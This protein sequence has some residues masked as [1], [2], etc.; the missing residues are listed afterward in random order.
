MK[1]NDLKRYKSNNRYKLVK[2]LQIKEIQSI[3]TFSAINSFYSYIVLCACSNR[4]L[5]IFDMNTCQEIHKIKDVHTRPIHSLC[6]NQGSSFVSQP[7]EAYD[8]FLTSAPTD[9]VKL[10][11][12]RVARCVRR[13]E[14]HANRVHKVGLAY[15]PCSKYIAV[16]SEDRSTYIYDIRSSSYLHRLT[17]QTEVVTSLA[18]HP[19]KPLLATGSLSG[20]IKTYGI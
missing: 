20:M 1:I 8:L 2:D 7:S 9:A 15:S 18:F 16:G 4:D 6:Q 14:G 3:T 13:Y 10:W 12:L 11:D 5:V 19:Q 17:G